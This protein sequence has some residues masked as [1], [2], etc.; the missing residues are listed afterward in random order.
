MTTLIHLNEFPTTPLYNIKAVVQ[1]TEISSSTLRAWE[2]RYNMC[3]PQRS[4]SG[5]RL[6]SDQ[7]IAIIRWLKAQVDAGMSISQAVSWMERLTEEAGGRGN[8]AL[9]TEAEATPRPTVRTIQ[10]PDSVR[11]IASLKSELYNALISYSES[12]AEDILAES[13]SLYTVETIGEELITPVLVEIGN[14]WHAGKLSITTE[15][16]ATGFLIQQLMAMLRM[17]SRS[18]HG[19]TIWVGCAPSELHEIGAILLTLYLRRN[20]FHV[21][22]LGRDLPEEDLIDEVR[23]QKPALLLFSAGSVEAAQGLQNL[24]QRLSQRSSASQAAWPLVGYGGRIFKQQPDLRDEIRG[25]YMGDTVSEAI[26]MV[27]EL[28][29]EARTD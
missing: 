12:A 25:V 28:L 29:S 4:A 22:Y 13:F 16:F 18:D 9:P 14:Q 10:R 19:P 3:Q 5:Y 15:H 24:T 7:D 21:Q 17:G 11:A 27:T 20:G 6:Y 26:D 2:R 1:A 8:A 23:R